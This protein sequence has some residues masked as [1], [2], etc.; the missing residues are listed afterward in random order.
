LCASVAY[1]FD[2]SVVCAASVA[3]KMCANVALWYAVSVAG[4]N[5]R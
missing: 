4:K 2:D 5:V 3:G 1:V